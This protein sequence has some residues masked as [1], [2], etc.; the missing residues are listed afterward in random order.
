MRSLD[1]CKVARGEQNHRSETLVGANKRG[2]VRTWQL[3]SA[4]LAESLHEK[5]LYPLSNN[6][7]IIFLFL[8]PVC[9]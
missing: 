1:F 5:L 2:M 3:R 8:S 7:N 6:N 9:L 4:A